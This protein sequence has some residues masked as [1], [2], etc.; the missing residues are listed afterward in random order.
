MKPKIKAIVFIII[1]FILG[2]VGGALLMQL[3]NKPTPPP[4]MKHQDFMKMM[5]E[6]LQLTEVQQAA[7]DSILE[8]SKEKIDIHKRAIF[9]IKDSVRK[10][11]DSILTKE[12]REKLE[13]IIKSAPEPGKSK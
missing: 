4:M 11:I 1:S 13:A 8:N 9:A 10:E 5:S 3:I 6:K 7:I 2:G 12:Q